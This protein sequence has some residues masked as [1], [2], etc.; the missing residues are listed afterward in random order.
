MPFNPPSLPLPNGKDPLRH[1]EIFRVK[2]VRRP[3]HV[4]D[5]HVIPDSAIEEARRR[6]IYP[7]SQIAITRDIKRIKRK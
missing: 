3:F 1:L 4:L 6:S 7:G 5:Y 2:L